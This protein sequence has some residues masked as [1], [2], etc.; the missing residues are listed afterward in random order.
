V[1]KYRNKIWYKGRGKILMK[2][3]GIDNG[4]TGAIAILDE[5]TVEFYPIPVKKELN[6]TKMKQWIHRV[7]TTKLKNILSKNLNS[8]VFIER[9]M[10]NPARFK[11]TVSAI[12]CLE[13]TLIVVEQLGYSYEYLDSK[14][15]QKYMLP[16]GLSGPELKSAGKE[17]AKRLYPHINIGSCDG[18][19]LL[20]ARYGWL[21]ETGQLGK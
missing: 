7:D 18:D 19:A 2:I 4:V 13:A 6:Y 14:E 10:V 3:V 20:I 12:R 8:K 21:K 9:P 17:V 1:G 5:Q 16:H 15:W 11:A